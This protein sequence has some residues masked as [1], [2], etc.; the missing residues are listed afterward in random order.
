MPEAKI[1]CHSLRTKLDDTR[2]VRIGP[3]QTQ[4]SRN[5]FAKPCTP[6]SLLR[7][8]CWR[9][10]MTFGPSR[11]CLAT[12]TSIPTFLTKESMGC[13]APWMGCKSSLYSLYKPDP[14]DPTMIDMVLILKDFKV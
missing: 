13:A 3:P 6:A 5:A 14:A 8:T 2:A 9:R 1:S 4:N 12:R 11:T 10:G 7:R